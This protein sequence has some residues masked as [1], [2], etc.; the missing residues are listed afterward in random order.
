M[1]YRVLVGAGGFASRGLKNTPK[2][3]FLPPAGGRPV[4]TLP[5]PPNQYNP[6]LYPIGD[7]FGFIV[8]IEDI[9]DW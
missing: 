5:A 7:G 4:R 2:D 8:Y 6:N 3:C 1:K 9:V